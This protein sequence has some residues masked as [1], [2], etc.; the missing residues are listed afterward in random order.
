MLDTELQPKFPLQGPLQER[1]SALPYLLAALLG[2]IFC[3]AL[4]FNAGKRSWHWLTWTT[5][6]AWAG[7]ML[8][9]GYEHAV[10]AY[11]NP[12]EWAALGIVALS[13]AALVATL[14]ARRNESGIVGFMETWQLNRKRL[15]PALRMLVLF[16]G[17]AGALL[18]LADPR[19]R[20]FPYALYALPLLA[21][22]TL[23]GFS[24]TGQEEKICAVLIAICGLGRSLMEPMNPQGQAW[25]VLCVLLAFAGL[26]RMRSASTAPTAEKSQL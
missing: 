26:A 2:A 23:R 14:T 5:A 17:A 24:A 11:R 1:A 10:V 9:L 22:L 8:W 13:G 21:L 15:V 6:G 18:L 25:A 12:L 7:G 19:Y 20:D 16:A 4:G 3:G